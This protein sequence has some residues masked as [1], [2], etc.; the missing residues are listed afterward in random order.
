[1]TLYIV[2]DFPDYPK[3]SGWP[4]KR[5]QQN[6]EE[7]QNFGLLRVVESF[8][9]GG[10][11]AAVKGV[12]FCGKLQCLPMVILPRMMM[13]RMKL[14]SG[15]QVTLLLAFTLS[16]TTT[17]F[18]QLGMFSTQQRIALTREWK[19][20]RFPDGRPKAPD[21]VLEGLKDVDA[22]EAR[23]R[24]G[25]MATSLSSRV[26]GARSIPVGEWWA[27]CSPPFSCPCGPT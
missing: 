22:E 13:R 15:F 12:P 19:G 2:V 9:S 10:L 6:L 5:R 27:A 21:S 20:E 26:A 1:M 3:D 17:A 7:Y 25:D 23:A 16:F 11:Q 8:R 24:C 4:R 18:P 14:T